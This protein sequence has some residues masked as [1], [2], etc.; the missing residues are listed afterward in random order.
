MPRPALTRRW[1]APEV[2]L[3]K[4]LW[5]T[6]TPTRFIAARLKR[7]RN[8]IFSMAAKLK[9]GRL[10]KAGV[11]VRLEVN[12]RSASAPVCRKCGKLMRYHSTQQVD[13]TAGGQPK[14]MLVFVC[15]ACD[16][17]RAVVPDDETDH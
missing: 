14:T 8:G 12:R 6:G 15:E 17:W 5:Q 13:F 10:N 7:S 2:E 16:K 1:T 11:H 3:L 4:R 9:I